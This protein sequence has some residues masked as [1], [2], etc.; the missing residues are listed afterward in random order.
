MLRTPESSKFL[1]DEVKIV[2]LRKLNV[3]YKNIFKKEKKKIDVIL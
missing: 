3:V 2:A 1:R